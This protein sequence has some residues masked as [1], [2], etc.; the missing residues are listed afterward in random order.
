MGMFSVASF[1]AQAAGDGIPQWMLQFGALG[2]CSF[3]VLQNYNQQRALSGVIERKDREIASLV[4][5]LETITL[6][7]AKAMNRLAQALED[8]PCLASDQRI[9][10]DR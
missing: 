6:Q 5:R 10:F 7:N 8:R 3:M 2:L 9:Y 4:N 1:W